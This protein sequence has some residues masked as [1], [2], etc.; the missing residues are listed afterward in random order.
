M[1]LIRYPPGQK[2]KKKEKEKGGDDESSVAESDDQ[3]T[4]GDS[5][6]SSLTG[7]QISSL[8]GGIAP[9][10]MTAKEEKKAKQN[11]DANLASNNERTMV[12]PEEAAAAYRNLVTDFLLN[13]KDWS[14]H[15]WEQ[16][17]MKAMKKEARLY[18][19]VTRI[20]AVWRGKRI[21]YYYEFY[22]AAI[23]TLQCHTRRRIVQRKVRAMMKILFED[24]LHRYRYYAATLLCALVRRYIARSRKVKIYKRLNEQQAKIF[25][26]NRK[27]KAKI[28]EKRRAT[29][30]YKVTQKVQGLAILI[31]VRRRDQRSYSKDYSM[32]LEV[33]VPHSQETFKFEI[34]EDDLRK[35]ICLET[36]LEV[37][38]NEQLLDK[39]NLSKVVSARLICKPAKAGMPPRVMF[40][41]QA[42]GERGTKC[43]TRGKVIGGDLFVCTLYQSSA[44]TSVQAYHRLTSKVFTARIASNTLMEW[45]TNEY[46]KTCTTELELYNTPPLLKPENSRKMFLWMIDNLMIDTRRGQF[47]VPICYIFI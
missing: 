8:Q 24:W 26:A 46:R 5:L 47:K 35:F 21:C 17:K 40:S 2:N 16:S 15:V 33:Y 7:S 22:K 19:A 25:K 42:L 3:S 43:C 45:I 1:A 23:L 30:I 29:I 28:N 12:S 31:C 41:K 6:N 39:R 13:I 36:G 38:N 11:A 34:E 14:V 32:V 27:R 18:A 20:I 9:K 44:E 10:K 4:G 37:L